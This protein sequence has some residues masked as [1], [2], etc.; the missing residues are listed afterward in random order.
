MSAETTIVT[1]QGGTPGADVNT[2]VFFNTATAFPSA[3]YCAMN[4]MKRLQVGLSNSQAGAYNWY[5]SNTRL[6]NP[7]ATP[8]WTQIGTV[9]VPI[10]ATTE[11]TNDFLIEEYADFKLEFVNGGVAQAT[12]VVNLALSGERVKGT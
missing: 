7:S 12:W 3:N 11:N 6:T 10:G 1:Y 4:R 8:V 2:Y 5:K 9:A